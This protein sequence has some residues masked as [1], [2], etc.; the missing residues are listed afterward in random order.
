M[1]V[2]TTATTSRATQH[3]LTLME[4]LVTLVLVALLSTLIVQ[5]VAF[6][7]VSYDAVKRNQRDA[8][9]VALQQR[10]FVS[11]VRGIVPYGL[12]AGRSKAMRRVS[13]P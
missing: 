1:T 10:W 6:F 8:T 13:R 4:L 2:N 11:S 9:H 3:G 7:G 12:R 5:A